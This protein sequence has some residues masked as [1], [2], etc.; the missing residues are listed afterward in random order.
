MCCLGARI[1]QVTDVYD[2]LTTDRPYRAALPREFAI[3]TMREEAGRGWWDS[4]LVEE[5]VAIVTGS[6]K[7][8]AEG[9]VS[10]VGY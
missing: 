8:V 4:S 7:F 6:Q 3:A 2:A 9:K 10:A 1:L 5:L